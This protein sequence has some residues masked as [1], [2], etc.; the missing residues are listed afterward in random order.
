M[1][2]RSSHHLISRPRPWAS[3]PPIVVPVV[4]Y[5]ISQRPF[6]MHSSAMQRVRRIRTAKRRKTWQMSG[7]RCRIARHKITNH[8]RAAVINNLPEGCRAIDRNMRTRLS[9]D[10]VITTPSPAAP[11]DCD[12]KLRPPTPITLV[13]LSAM[14][15]TQQ[16]K[17]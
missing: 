15:P 5:F 10:L 13:A 6:R 14:A 4:A 9:S 16:E 12:A 11:A 2:P 1:P 17:H 8:Q 7:R 3:P